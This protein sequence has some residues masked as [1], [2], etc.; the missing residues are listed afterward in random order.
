[1]RFNNIIGQQSVRK[2]LIQVV[3]NG[4]VGHALLFHGSEGSGNFA[5]AV[6]F[7]GYIFCQNP[8]EDDRCGTCPSCRKMDHFGHPDL[9]F[10]FPF[11]K[12]DKTD[13]CKPYYRDFVAAALAN[14]YL[15]L[16][17]W[18][19]VMGG[20]NKKPIITTDEAAEIV[21]VLSLK[22]FER[23]HKVVIVWLAEKL[24]ASAANR[25]LKTLE[26]P[27]EK[28][29]IILV[30]NSTEDM[31]ATIISRTQLVKCDRLSE[32]ELTR[33][34]TEKLGASWEAA[35][36][37][38]WRAEGNFA[39]AKQILQEEDDNTQYLNLFVI[40]MRACVVSNL[41]QA[42]KAVDVLTGMSKESQK[43]F[44]EYCLHFLHDSLVF[45]FAGKD[46]ARFDK[47]AAEFAARFAPI[48]VAN[49]LQGFHDIFSRGHYMI[50]R[51]AHGPLLFM[52]MS[53]DMMK[54]FSSPKP[55]VL[56]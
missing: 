48:I 8:G 30:V 22:S 43:H 41:D 3:K 14:P 34:L 9:H 49:D 13:T 56:S 18:E 51:N 32:G 11:I 28:T 40:W 21:K 26:E 44:L 52:K 33:A 35:E 36:Q 19:K 25:L 4:H 55:E 46:N 12:T 2:R 6:A 7:A 20:E 39:K 42:L 27:C 17:D 23:G 5:L 38:A 45:T 54:I 50:E 16:A 47:N 53:H 15:T 31:L 24:N 1:V 10:S 37:I 29:L